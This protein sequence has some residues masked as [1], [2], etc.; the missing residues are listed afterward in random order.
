MTVKEYT[1]YF[2]KLNIR[3]GQRKR[4]EDK[5]SRYINGL[6][7][8]IQDGI[9]MISMRT[10]DGAYQYALKAEDKLARK[11]IQRSRGR[12]L[13]ISKGVTHDTT[14]KPKGEDEKTHSHS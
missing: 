5:I 6:R 13:N 4:D 14:Q 9:S 3:T 1:K 12:S 10:V 7:Y 8:D 2:Y 11:Q